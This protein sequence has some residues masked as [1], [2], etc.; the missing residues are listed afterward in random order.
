MPMEPLPSDAALVEYLLG[1]ADPADVERFDNLSVSD[2]AF[3]ERLR[4]LEH[5]LADAYARGELSAA[6]RERWETRYLASQHGR[7][8]LALAEALVA[9]E[10]GGSKNPPNDITSAGRVS[11][12]RVFGPRTRGAWWLLAAAAVLL[13]ASAGGYRVLHRAEPP[14]TIARESPVVTPAPP[15]AAARRVVALTLVPSVRSLRAPPTLTIP[16]GTTDAMLTLTLEPGDE[17]K[18]DV[19]LRDLSTNSV[20]W[21]ADRVAAARTDPDRALVVSVPAS[22]FHTR[23][24][25]INVMRSGT[26]EILASY[27]LVVVVQ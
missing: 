17:P 18:Y 24:Y 23:R 11:A 7:D 6:D 4:A 10:R 12:G 16:P 1:G 27:P 3:A 2:A 20:A 26:E 22:T 21:R 19:A 9:R 25:L 5:D 15:P 8:D 13:L 14:A